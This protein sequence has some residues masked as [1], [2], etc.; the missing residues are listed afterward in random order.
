MNSET[1]GN[2]KA[3]SSCLLWLIAALLL[4]KGC[5]W[6]SDYEKKK[7]REAAAR[8]ERSLIDGR[9]KDSIREVFIADSLDCDPHYQDSLRRAEEEY[10]KFEDK[11]KSIKSIEIIGYMANGDSVYHTTFHSVKEIDE[12]PCG[13][14]IPDVHKLRFITQKDEQEN[15]LEWCNECRSMDAETLIDDGELIYREDAGD[16]CNHNNDY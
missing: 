7:G 8:E 2:I 13:F 3:W 4:Y 14:T 6:Y 9:Q 16:Y 1:K 5:D 10:R 15:N 12:F 11:L